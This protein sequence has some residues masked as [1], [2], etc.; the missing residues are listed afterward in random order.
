MGATAS[1]K[2]ADTPLAHAL[3]YARN[4][5]LSGR[6]ELIAKNDQRATITLWRGRITLVQTIP[7]GLVPGGYFGSVAY[8]LGFIDAKTLDSTLA[9]IAKTKKLHG[10]LLIEKEKIDAVQRDQA[11]VEQIHRKIHYL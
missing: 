8:E 6:L 3:I 9:E 4:R 10:Q 1:G 5:R 11:L 2:L 7:S